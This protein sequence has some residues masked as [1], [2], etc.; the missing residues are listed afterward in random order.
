M[1]E[2]DAD[3]QQKGHEVAALRHWKT[4]LAACK[5]EGMDD[6]TF[7]AS[8]GA[9]VETLLLEHPEHAEPW[10]ARLNCNLRQELDLRRQ[11]P[12]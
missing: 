12:S 8:L 6:V 9:N 2:E 10:L 3:R 4:F 1:P 7:L 5:Q 11:E